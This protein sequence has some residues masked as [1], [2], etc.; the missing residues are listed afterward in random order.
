LI[1]AFDALWMQ[2]KLSGAMIAAMDPVMDDNKAE[3]DQH[4]SP[5]ADENLTASLFHAAATAVDAP[6]GSTSKMAIV[7]TSS[8]LQHGSSNGAWW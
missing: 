3:V 5:V 7:P 8:N 1:E 2:P 6:L 4:V